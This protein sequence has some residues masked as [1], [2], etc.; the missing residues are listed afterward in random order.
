MSSAAMISDPVRERR[1]S[2]WLASPT[3]WLPLLTLAF[4]F[5]RA[6]KLIIS[7][8]MWFE[9]V[10]WFYP[11][12]VGQG[13]THAVLLIYRENYQILTNVI[14]YA[15]TLLPIE[16][17]AYVTAYAAVLVQ[18]IAACLL[19]F[20]ME[21]Y[22][23][24]NWL[25]LPL[26]C[27]WACLP[28]GYEVF[29]TATNIQWVCSISMLFILVAPFRSM[30]RGGRAALY[31]WCLA[32]GLTG[33][34]SAMLCW[35]FLLRAW[36]VRN[37]G[38][39]HLAV[40]LILTACIVLQTAVLFT[41]H[42]PEARHFTLNPGLLVVPGFLQT[43]LTPLLGADIV[44]AAAVRINTD[45]AQKSAILF[46]VCLIASSVFIMAG[47]LAW[48]SAASRATI[49][50]LCAI[51]IGVT[52]INTFGAIGNPVSLVSALHNG[53]YFLMG[54][55]CFVLLLT[56]AT[57]SSDTLARQISVYL[58]CFL[59]VMSAGEVALTP[60]NW[61]LFRF[62]PSWQELVDSCHGTRPCTVSIFKDWPV[63]LAK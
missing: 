5:L 33:L 41:H 54:I 12:L 43:G 38:T 61:L 28:E 30:S 50:L 3:I 49:L 39:P 16:Y 55:M 4:M 23:I 24:R 53:R 31:I 47:R 60:W 48:N 6:P 10:S 1:R 13:L 19:G 22:G 59:A 36:W 27:V 8:R 9:E 63:T 14:V 15:A 26:A 45:P 57:T 44:E 42:P 18:M 58:I 56:L 34:P 40:G 2:I 25:A 32:C 17:A 20:V 46:A 21:G 51:W 29:A 35:A 52:L 37:A 62:G 7:P 11:E